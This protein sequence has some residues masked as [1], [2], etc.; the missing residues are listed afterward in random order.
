MKKC[1][2]CG[3]RTEEEINFCPNCGERLARVIIKK[4]EPEPEPE[5]VVEEEETAVETNKP[6]EGS[7][8][9]S[10]FNEGFKKA[11]IFELIGDAIFLAFIVCL[12]FLRIFK[13]EGIAIL[14][15][16]NKLI[17]TDK[18]SFY[19]VIYA[20]IRSAKSG[21]SSAFIDGTGMYTTIFSIYFIVFA[22]TLLARIIT[23]AIKAIN[24]NDYYLEKYN[25]LVT[26][27]E[28]VTKRTRSANTLSLSISCVVIFVFIYIFDKFPYVGSHLYN[29]VNGLV[30]VLIILAVLGLAALIYAKIQTTTIKKI[31]LRELNK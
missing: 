22:I 15:T 2:K 30:S 26:N 7:K 27:N 24:M 5:L 6:V 21:N 31:Y 8:D 29:G 4:K 19:D 14:E 9:K 20:F 11:L 25:D 10:R 1:L 12:F 13:L 23:L 28:G 17:V 3:F 16:N 18:I